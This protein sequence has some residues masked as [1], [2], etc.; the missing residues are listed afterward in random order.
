MTQALL[1]KVSSNGLPPERSKGYDLMGFKAEAVDT[2]PDFVERNGITDYIIF[3]SGEHGTKSNINYSIRFRHSMYI[4]NS[5]PAFDL[6]ISKVIAMRLVK[7][8]MRNPQ[9]KAFNESFVPEQLVMLQLT[10]PADQRH[11][12]AQTA[13]DRMSS[14]SDTYFGILDSISNATTA[15]QVIDLTYPTGISPDF[16]SGASVL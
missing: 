13:I 6:E 4:E 5:T 1:Y 2:A 9:R 16:T 7:D 10:L 12:L 14:E 11:P 3:E 15:E 8:S